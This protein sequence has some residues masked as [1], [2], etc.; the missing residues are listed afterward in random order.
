MKLFSS[1]VSRDAGSTNNTKI[2]YTK[3]GTGESSDVDK[4]SRCIVMHIRKTVPALNTQESLHYSLMTLHKN[5]EVVTERGHVLCFPLQL[6]LAGR[7]LVGAWIFLHIW[8]F[9]FLAIQL[10]NGVYWF[11]GPFHKLNPTWKLCD[12]SHN[13]LKHSCFS[14]AV[15]GITL[16]DN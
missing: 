9:S 10:T 4:Q 7:L 8:S 11:N 2:M 15:F 1:L 16:T 13:L 14:C 6:S 12:A 5:W 3:V